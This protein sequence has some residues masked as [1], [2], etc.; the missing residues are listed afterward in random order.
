MVLRLKAK[1]DSASECNG[2]EILLHEMPEKSV[3]QNTS[4]I[5]K[6]HVGLRQEYRPKTC[7][8]RGT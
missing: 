7:H 8:M 1:K 4:M 6:Q 2:R 5:P 3:E